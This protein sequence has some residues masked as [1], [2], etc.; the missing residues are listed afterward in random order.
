MAVNVR[1][2]LEDSVITTFYETK[3]GDSLV[4]AGMLPFSADLSAF[5]GTDIRL[6]IEF[7]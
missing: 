4:L 3:A 7:S 2:P 5:A 1:D 6:D